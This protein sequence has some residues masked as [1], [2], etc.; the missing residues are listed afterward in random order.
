MIRGLCMAGEFRGA[1]CLVKEMEASWCN[2]NIVV[3]STL[4]SYLRKAGKLGEARK[5]IR[6][7]VK[8]GHYVHLVP[9]MM[10]YRR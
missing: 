7:M 2:P 5:V 1:C 6:D 3:Y 9:K 4:V 10:K 8:K